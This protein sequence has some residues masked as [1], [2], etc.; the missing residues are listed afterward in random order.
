[1][2]HWETGLCATLLIGISDNRASKYSLPRIS[3]DMAKGDLL[4]FS[5]SC[6]TANW[7]S[8][9]FDSMIISPL[10]NI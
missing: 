8:L 10:S 9:Y 1:M 7:L 4:V 5:G 3:R 2:C 6:L